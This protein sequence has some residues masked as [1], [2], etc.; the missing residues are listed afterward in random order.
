[1]TP[2]KFRCVLWRQKTRVLRLSCSIIYVILRLVSPFVSRAER[3]KTLG[4]RMFTKFIQSAKCP[5]FVGETSAT[6]RMHCTYTVGVQ[7]HALRDNYC[8]P[9]ML[10]YVTLWTPINYYRSTISGIWQVGSRSIH[11]HSS[12]LWAKKTTLLSVTSRNA[13]RYTK[14][15]YC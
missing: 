2:F 10:H 12:T 5:R 14:L 3:A 4:V 1:M 6:Q 15:L 11:V 13:N 7:S 9:I 8:S